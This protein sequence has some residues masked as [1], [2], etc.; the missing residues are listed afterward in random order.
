M[1]TKKDVKIVQPPVIEVPP[2][3]GQEYQF[4]NSAKSTTNSSE[5]TATPEV[6]KAKTLPPPQYAHEVISHRLDTQRGAIKSTFRF[7][8]FG[9]LKIGVKDETGQIL[10]TGDGITAIDVNGQTTF[11]IDGTTG[12]ATFSGTIAAQNILTGTI[13]MGTDGRIIGGDGD[14][15]R[16]ILG[17]LQS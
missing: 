2:L 8:E 5:K 17:K 10:I 7:D 4:D 9:A 13:D 6:T 11:N 15:Y 14:H 3:A 1:A 12:N 16:W